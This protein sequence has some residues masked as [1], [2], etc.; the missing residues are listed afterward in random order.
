MRFVSSGTSERFCV[1]APPNRS[2]LTRAARWDVQS[3]TVFPLTHGFSE[4]CPVGFS[5]AIQRKYFCTTPLGCWGTPVRRVPAGESSKI[6]FQYRRLRRKFLLEQHGKGIPPTFVKKTPQSRALLPA[7]PVERV[8]GRDSYAMGGQTA[9]VIRWRE[10]LK[11]KEGW[12]EGPEGAQ[13]LTT[14]RSGSPVVKLGV[15]NKLP[16][17]N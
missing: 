6:S 9:R 16:A 1:S 10:S 11:Y 3:G 4:A 13:Q 14:R 7:A 8:Q 5:P 2:S 12:G 15:I 17:V